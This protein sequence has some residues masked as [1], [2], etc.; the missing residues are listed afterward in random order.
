MERVWK[1]GTQGRDCVFHASH[2]HI[3][4]SYNEYCKFNY[5]GRERDVMD[6]SAQR[7]FGVHATRPSTKQSQE[8][9][10]ISRELYIC[11]VI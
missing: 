5:G 7:E 8:E 6:I 2:T 11:L 1:R 10:D 3:R 4:N 9:A